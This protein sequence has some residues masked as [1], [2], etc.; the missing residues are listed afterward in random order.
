MIPE[1]GIAIVDWFLSLL[2]SLG[3]LIVFA[4]TVFENIFVVGSMTP[5]ETVVVAA[6]FVS[7]SGGLVLAGV[8][9]VRR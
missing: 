7:S 6:A 4:F 3:Y 9:L 5:G 1:T 8:W 2:D